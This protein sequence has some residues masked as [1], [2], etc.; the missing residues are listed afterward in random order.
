MNARLETHLAARPEA[1]L[2]QLGF[3]FG[4]SGT[5]SARS[6]ML[7]D[8]RRLFAHLPAHATRADYAQAVLADNLLGKPTKN[9]RTFSLGHLRSLY[10]LDTQR[11]L[12]RA[13]R[14]LW[15]QDVSAQPVLALTAALAR[16][17][18]LRSSQS[19]IL[20][21]PLGIHVTRDA[22]A[23]HLAHA[24]QDRFSPASLKSFAQNINGSWTK[25]GY[26]NGHA[27]KTR[28]TPTITP[29]NVAFC[30]FLGHLE[31]LSG[32]RLFSSGW[33]HL[34]PA[35]PDELERLARA[36]YQRGTLVYLNAGGVKELRFPGYL[37]PEEQQRSQENT[38]VF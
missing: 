15:A 24:H 12:F 10:G 32:Q 19:F 30:L 20:G 17:P 13:L 22:L 28:S 4:V 36:A 6:M 23:Q 37:R 34:L 27:R 38:H 29:V 9:S 2:T 11:P 5:H 18:L 25:A 31:G 3:R 33:M 7:D 16:D 14:H 21:Q 8:L 26:L 1:H 35:A